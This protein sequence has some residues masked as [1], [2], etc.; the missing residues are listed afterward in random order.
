M[1][2]NLPRPR[3]Y[4]AERRNVLMVGTNASC[5]GGIASVVRGY[6]QSGIFD[7]FKV[8]YVSTHCDGRAVAK[9]MAAIKGWSLFVVHCVRLDAPL[10][11]IHT[12]SRLSFWRKYVVCIIARLFR[13]PYILHLHGGEFVDFYQSECGPL[14]KRLIRISFQRAAR[15]AVLSG[16]WKQRISNLF[17]DVEVEVV[18][19]A[20][21]LPPE[22]ATVSFGSNGKSAVILFVGRLVKG[23]GI[24]DLIG[25]FAKVS[26]EFPDVKLVCIGD[27]NA[28]LVRKLAVSLG[29]GKRVECPGWIDPEQCF[30]YYRGSSIFVLPSYAEGLPIALLEAM[31]WQLAIIS[32]PVGG[33]PEL[34]Q[35]GENGL[36]VRPGDIDGLANALRVLLTDPKLRSRLSVAARATIEEKYSTESNL[37]CLRQLYASCGLSTS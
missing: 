10:V 8:T 18:S 1:K 17:G 9:V 15:V 2:N 32:C 4:K 24:N 34:V 22:S 25:A 3:Q 28:D 16:E 23:K 35:D 19:N 31:S 7:E 29:V 11:H 21:A 14:A 12:A 20:V 33:I 26:T 13:Y 6:Q 37:R 30:E 27:G 5:K 36:L